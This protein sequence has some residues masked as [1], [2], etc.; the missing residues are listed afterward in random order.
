[1]RNKLIIH[2]GCHKTGTTAL[3][4]ALYVNNKVLEKEN[5]FN[6]I[7]GNNKNNWNIVKQTWK[8]KVRFKK[9]GCE[10]NLENSMLIGEKSQLTR[11]QH[12][13]TY[14]KNSDN[15]LFIFSSENLSWLFLESE[16][17]QL[18]LILSNYFSNIL[19]IFYVRRQDLLLRSH[20][21]QG[22]ISAP[23]NSFYDNSIDPNI[24][25]REHFDLYYDFQKRIKKWS[26]VFGRHNVNVHV[27]DRNTLKNG[28]I[29]TDFF[30]SLNLENIIN[31][32][33]V[34]D[35]Q[36][37]NKNNKSREKL[38]RLVNAAKRSGKTKKQLLGVIRKIT[39]D[40]EPCRLES[41]SIWSNNVLKRYEETNQI[42]SDEFNL[43]HD[44]YK[45]DINERQSNWTWNEEKINIILANLLEEYLEL[46][47]QY[48]SLLDR[49]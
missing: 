5:I 37:I 7:I 14:P 8:D 17:K 11:N 46:E 35:S 31:K 43:G 21:G 1:M 49:Q 33:N 30:S 9:Y 13:S 48:I 27:M 19:I 26:N 25:L 3:Q 34:S 24:E 6:I 2:A 39:R 22:S 10:L 18:Q 42:L 29:T 28:D 41:S 15:R 4:H 40:L 47:E 20:H 36:N 32:I 23:A 38:L 45:P 44:W 12:A 16:I